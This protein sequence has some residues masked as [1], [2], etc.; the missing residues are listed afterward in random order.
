MS[1]ESVTLGGA[2]PFNSRPSRWKPKLLPSMSSLSLGPEDPAAVGGGA[3][4][5][6]RGPAEQSPCDP[7]A[8]TK[9]GLRNVQQW[10]GRAVGGGPVQP[11]GAWLCVG[12]LMGWK[13]CG[14]RPH[15]AGRSLVLCRLTWS[16]SECMDARGEAWECMSL[17]DETTVFSLKACSLKTVHRI[18]LTWGKLFRLK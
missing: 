15:A 16:S 18:K 4:Q 7:T 11:A 14:R 5:P 8:G 2:A 3:P 10:G 6:I 12:C 9:C 1:V 17:A 13:G